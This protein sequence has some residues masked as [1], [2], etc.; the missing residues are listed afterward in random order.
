[1]ASDPIFGV[2]VLRTESDSVPVITAD[3]SVVGIVGPADD[4][5]PSIYP[6]DTPVLVISN[7][8]SRVNALG[9]DG[10]LKDAVRGVNGQ[11]AASQRAAV[12]VLVRTA[13]GVNAD[14]TIANQLTIAKIMGD[15]SLG[16]GQYALLEA[17]E[18][19]Q[20]TPRLI[21]Y[22]GF[23]GMLANGV[24]DLVA[25]T[26]GR[27]YVPGATYPLTFTGGGSNVIQATG[28]AVAA[29]DGT[30]GTGNLVI[31]T[32]GQ[33]YTSAPV[34]A[35]G[36]AAPTGSGAT[37]LVVTASIDQLAN[38]ICA[39][40]PVVLDQLLAHA[41]VESTG[42]SL[43]AS[44]QWRETLNSQRLIPVHGGV[45]VADT[46][47]GSVVV[48][49]QA[50]R[51][52]GIG[53]RRDYEKGAPFHSWANQPMYDVV[54]PQHS[55]TFSIQDGAN[56][57][58]LL[59]QANIG[60]LVSGQIGN[61]FAIADGGYLFVGTDNAGDDEEWRF[62]NQTRGRDFLNIAAI[63]ATR[64][65]LGRE[66]ID[67]Q[68]V[69]KLLNTLRLMLRDYKATNK[70]LGYDVRFTGNDN[71]REGIRAGKLRIRY[72]AE[73]PPVLRRVDVLS[74]R[75]PEA[76]DSLIADLEATSVIVA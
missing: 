13:R 72:R 59:L 9:E 18:A 8:K 55:L 65:F 63:R 62:Y 24:D 17:P 53:V 2:K 56:E 14:P 46:V 5:D 49:P 41:V 28:H 64:I 48:R 58:Q 47:T 40:A 57:G 29:A 6:L 21:C 22:P 71:S 67:G 16:T 34:V 3:L 52:I 27:G 20:C 44:Q 1:M 38:P 26:V 42:T 11:L 70:I 25:S 4:A 23:T 37:A 7:D 36:G 35:V 31:D 19:L 68:S 60:V 15:A 45:K 54:G 73:E 32:T 12:I 75:M 30:I 51:V 76:V 74:G 10:F 43:Q 50:P 61:D 39:A 33:W 69:Q 66:N